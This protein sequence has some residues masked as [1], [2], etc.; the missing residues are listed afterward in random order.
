MTQLDPLALY[1]L[2]RNEPI[3]REV[4]A[5]IVSEK[6]IRMTLL[7]KGALILS[8]ILL[9]ALIITVVIKLL[10]GESWEHLA[11][12]MVPTVYLFIWPFIVWGGARASRFGKVAA[13]MLKAYE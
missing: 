10:G 5:V 1:V 4:V 13:A 11:R 6:G 12:R 7:E 8:L 9:A 2:Q 3:E